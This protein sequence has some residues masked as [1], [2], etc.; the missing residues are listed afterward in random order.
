VISAGNKPLEEL[1]KAKL[2]R[3]DLY[4]RLA[5]LPLTVPSLRE[6]TEDIPLLVDHFLRSSAH[7]HGRAP[8]SV[9]QE[10][11]LAL[12]HHQWPGN[13][14]ELE[15]VIER[16]VVTCQ[17]SI[18]RPEDLFVEHERRQEKNDLN[19]IGKVAR[20]DAERRQILQALRDA[21][22]DKTRA[23]RLLSISRSSLYN[24]LRDYKIS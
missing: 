22:G 21:K 9:S 7:K 4:Y 14:R 16:V 13:V 24:K 1:V 6:R 8:M 19:R 10:A 15:N 17:H 18:L 20:Q 3:A 2:F 11:Q 5:V 23:A 12:V